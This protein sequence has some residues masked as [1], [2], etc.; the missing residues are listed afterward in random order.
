MDGHGR[1]MAV[2][3]EFVRVRRGVSFRVWAPDHERVA[4]QVDGTDYEMV[5]EGGGYFE[6]EV[7]TALAGSRY[8]F[9]LGGE[10]AGAPLPDPASRCQPDGPHGL[11][12]VVDPD[13]FGWTDAD[14]PGLGLDGQVIQEIHVGTFTPEGTWEAAAEKLPLLLGVG[15]SCI[16]MMPVAAFPGRFGWG[17]DGVG[18]FAPTA[19]YG[20][21]DDLRRFVDRAHGLGM[22][23]ILDVVYNHFGP[24]GQYAGRFAKAYFSDCYE[25]EWGDPLN[26]DGPGS[27][28]VRR[29]FVDNAAYWIAEFH[30]DGLRFDA[31]QQIYDAS[32]VHIVADCA[33]AARAAA[34][35]R[36]LLLTAENTPQDIRVVRPGGQGGF[37][38]DAIWNEDFQRAARVAL[39]GER[40]AYYRDHRGSAPE[41]AAATVFGFLYQG[42][43]SGWEK[44]PRGSPAFD[45]P[46][47]RFITFLENHDQV[48]N[49]AKAARLV[50]LSNAGLLRAI[51]ALLLLGP[52]TPL[53][54]QGQ[55][56]G[57]SKPFHYFADFSG[58]LGRSVAEG[59]AGFMS[60][61]PDAV[62]EVLADPTA[63]A[64]WRACILDWSERDANA[65]WVALHRDLIRVR[66]TDPVIAG[67]GADGLVSTTPFPDLAAIRYFAPDL[68]DGT[69]VGDRLL[70]VNCGEAL[71]LPTVPDPLFAPGLDRPWAT[72]WSSED[73]LYG[74]AGAKPVCHDEGWSIPARAAVLLAP[75]P[76]QTGATEAEPPASVAAPR[77]EPASAAPPAPDLATSPA[78]ASTVAEA[79]VP[80]GA[81]SPSPA[82]PADRAEPETTSASEEPGAG[83]AIS[84]SVG[85]TKGAEPARSGEPTATEIV[86]ASEA[87]A[88]PAAAADALPD[89]A[90]PPG[91]GDTAETPEP[92]PPEPP[93]RREP[94][95]G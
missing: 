72:L 39:T 16:E 48:A 86:V 63:E 25:N 87:A 79:P 90:P 80:R 41:L 47:P 83:G 15:I 20:T 55:E 26:F 45:L 42:Q 71:D 54:F 13:G 1:R 67:Q 91:G 10:G 8:G 49:S 36:R 19:Q 34:G 43:R 69:V 77:S 7:S 58:D 29:F 64:T 35:H 78:G 17:Y 70:L 93:D 5:P 57:A 59:R 37:G 50:T 38:L 31:T 68:Q 85:S 88:P 6:T 95:S 73:A 74:G 61:F 12:M 53:L 24:D 46:I 21:P 40:V 44:Q 75:M 3:A 30:F 82:S 23:V 14:W 76:P 27:A 66:R 18:L 94:G 51:T 11:S 4:V 32:P 92:V 52:Q 81:E 89:P 33:A 28:G 84:A 65:A 56:F 2:G 62:P 22:G 60:Q 9:V